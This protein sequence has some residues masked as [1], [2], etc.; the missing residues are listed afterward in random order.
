MGRG[1]DVIRMNTGG[2]PGDRP[3]GDEGLREEWAKVADGTEVELVS[4]GKSK[5]VTMANRNE[6]V[7]LVVQTRLYESKRQVDAIR[8]GLSAVVPLQLLSLL[9]WRELEVH[10]CGRP[11]MDVQLLKSNTS[12]RGCSV[13]DEHIGFFWQVRTRAVCRVPV[14]VL[15]RVFAHR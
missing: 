15:A 7:D 5:P 10:V 1:R 13:H 9:N 12:Y 14:P 4:G 8:R 3:D 2:R 6:W 11:V